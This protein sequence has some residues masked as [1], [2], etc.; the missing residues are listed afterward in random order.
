MY[1]CRLFTAETAANGRQRISCPKKIPHHDVQSRYGVSWSA[2]FGEEDGRARHI[3]RKDRV[4]TNGRGGKTAD[5]LDNVP[6]IVDNT[7]GTQCASTIMSHG[8]ASIGGRVEQRQKTG[9]L[10]MAA[11]RSTAES[12][13]SHFRIGG[14]LRRLALIWTRSRD[15]HTTYSSVFSR[16]D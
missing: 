9:C 5:R 16:W 14:E 12:T 8:A 2:G 6:G 4:I 1:I 10:V 13:Y 11:I 15:G 3:H 7:V